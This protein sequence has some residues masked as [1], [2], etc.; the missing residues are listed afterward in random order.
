MNSAIMDASPSGLAN[1]VT[2]IRICL[3]L[4]VILFKSSL[5]FSIPLPERPTTIPG[6]EVCSSTSI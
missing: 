2:L 6:L 5:I 3:E 1:S 4:F